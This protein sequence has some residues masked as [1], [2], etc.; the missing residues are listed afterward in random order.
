MKSWFNFRRSII[1]LLMQ[2]T[3]HGY[4]AL[5]RIVSA[6]GLQAPFSSKI[7]PLQSK[8][9]AHS[10]ADDAM[11]SWPKIKSSVICLQ[12]LILLKAMI[13]RLI[14]SECMLQAWLMMT[15]LPVTQIPK[16]FFLNRE[17]HSI[18][19]RLTRLKARPSTWEWKE[20]ALDISGFS[21]NL[22]TAASHA[23]T[24]SCFERKNSA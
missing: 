11:C 15:R 16:Q 1:S 13:L 17:L 23:R 6:M 7:L 3:V 5:M 2:I 4:V 20:K 8:W 12:I 14:L 21:R 9:R 18:V 24:G 10:T 19:A 22:S